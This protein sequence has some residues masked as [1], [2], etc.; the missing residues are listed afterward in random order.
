MQNFVANAAGSLKEARTLLI[1]QAQ[2]VKITNA[3]YEDMIDLLDF[4]K[5]LANLQMDLEV[6]SHKYA[7]APNGRTASAGAGR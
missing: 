6:L 5:R 3:N 7:E 2:Q 1:Q 4:A